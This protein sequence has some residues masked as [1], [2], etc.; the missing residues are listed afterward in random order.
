MGYDEQFES[1]LTKEDY[2]EMAVMCSEAIKKKPTYQAIE[3]QFNI[4][5]RQAAKVRKILI[6]R[7]NYN[8]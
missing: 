7:L 4:S 3:N 2:I 5:R 8:N 6:D 1:I